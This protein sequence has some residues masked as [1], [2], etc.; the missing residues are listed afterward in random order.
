MSDFKLVDTNILVYSHDN[1]SPNH[2]AAKL[3]LESGLEKSNL[4]VSIQNFLEYFSLVT[5]PKNKLAV[6]AI[7]AGDRIS[8]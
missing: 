3:F 1:K 2:R 8:K 5:N 7:L 6:S 4:A